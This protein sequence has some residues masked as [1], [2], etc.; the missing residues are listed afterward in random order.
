MELNIKITSV[1]NLDL[2]RDGGTI[3]I[4]CFGIIS[5]SPD[6]N[7][8]EICLSNN[9]FGKD[10]NKPRE[11]WLGHPSKEDSIRITNPDTILNIKEKVGEFHR[12]N[13][14]RVNEILKHG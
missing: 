5:Q 13:E 6:L 11:F 2:Y 7:V 1:R 14:F 3:G 8:F 9:R 4:K 10:P 12:G